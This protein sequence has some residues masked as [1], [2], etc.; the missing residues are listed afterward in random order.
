[1]TPQ[2]LLIHGLLV[3]NAGNAPTPQARRSALDRAR[4]FRERCEVGS[5]KAQASER[6][7]GPSWDRE[8]GD[9]NP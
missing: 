9:E 2:Q 6:R 5:G 4:A 7:P 1:M 8:V 3:A